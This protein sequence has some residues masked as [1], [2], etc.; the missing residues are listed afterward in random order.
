[1][2]SLY[3]KRIYMS[4]AGVSLRASDTPPGSGKLRA[5]N[6][7]CRVH[8]PPTRTGRSSRSCCGAM[9][10]IATSSCCSALL[11]CASASAPTYR[12][13]VSGL[14]AKMNRP[15]TC[16][17]G[18]LKTE[19]LVPVDAFVCKLVHRLRLLRSQDPLPPDGFLLARPTGRDALIYKLRR[20]WKNIVAAAGITPELSLTSCGTPLAR[21][22]FERASLYP[23]S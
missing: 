2:E 5:V 18:K 1:M 9:I 10:E 13:I 16:P 8:L 15:S 21:R 19:R 17:P 12:S 6:I 14:S 22:C 4:R 3:M 20:V 11:A 23:P 7:I